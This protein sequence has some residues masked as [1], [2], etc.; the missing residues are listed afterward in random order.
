VDIQVEG[1]ATDRRSFPE[2]SSSPPT[3]RIELQPDP[4]HE[5]IRSRLPTRQQVFQ[6]SQASK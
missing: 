5:L 2:S 1:E 3:D 4:F 6:E